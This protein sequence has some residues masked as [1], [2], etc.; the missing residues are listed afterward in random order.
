MTELLYHTAHRG[1]LS[2]G[3]Y[4][5]IPCSGPLQITVHHI[6]ES[7]I[8][9]FRCR[10]AKGHLHGGA[11]TQS[12]RLVCEPS[13]AQRRCDFLPPQSAVTGSPALPRARSPLAQVQGAGKWAQSQ[14][15]WAKNLT[16][17]LSNS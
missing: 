4:N 1:D 10:T 16:S 12:V 13:R 8:R 9:E 7:R 11:E 3:S 6:T 17:T 2:K 15:I 5:M 14:K